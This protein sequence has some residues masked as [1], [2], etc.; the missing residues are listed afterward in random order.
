MPFHSLEIG[1]SFDVAPRFRGWFVGD[2]ATWAGATAQDAEIL[3]RSP[4]QSS[5]LQVKW[6]V[7][8]AGDRRAAW[9]DPDGHW[10]LSI[11]I[12]GDLTIDFEHVTQGASC[13]L[14][15]QRGDYAIWHGGE[16]RHTWRSTQGATV[17][18]MRWPVDNA[19]FAGGA[20]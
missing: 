13:A 17:L 10:S 7:H 9:A 12:D 15:R 5:S 14:L 3:S 11:V 2:L 19:S 1:N 16:Y 6:H 20:A 4:R 18:T 8:P